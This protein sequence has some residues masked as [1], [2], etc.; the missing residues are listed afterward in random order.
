[1]RSRPQAPP[2]VRV[3]SARARRWTLSPLNADELF[4]ALGVLPGARSVKASNGLG[5]SRVL[6]GVEVARAEVVDE[7][8]LRKAWRERAKG[9]PVPLLVVVDDPERDGAVRT[10]GPL[11]ADDPV[12]VVE[13][14]DL[15][16]VLEEL[17]SLSKLRAVRELA[18][19]LDRL[20]R[21]GIAG[22]SVKGL[23]TEH[24]YGTRLP[25]SPRWSELQGLVP[26]ARG[27]WREVLESFG[28]EVE[29]LK[30]RGYLARH[31][32]RPVAVVWPLNDPAAF[33]R[34]DHE[35]R[36]PEGLLVN[37]CIHEGASYGLL[38]SGA[39]LRRFRAQ[40]QQGSAVSS[41]L[42][43]DAASLA[44]DHRPLLGLLSPAYLAGDGFEGL[45]REAA[46]FGAELRERLDRSIR[47]D[48]LPPLGLEL[49]RWAEGEGRDLSD[50]ETRG[51]RR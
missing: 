28:Y 41:Y 3:T 7:R 17:P 16:R 51:E 6:A 44:A 36:P 21:T 32:G 8:A 38:A 19:E 20:D 10:L 43:L 18:E 47:E 40:P 46:A 15:L 5:S 22:L 24:L 30:R 26:D 23:G 4:E 42:E 12:R 35:G 11:G 25:G 49:G 39:R 14:D 2:R 45:M 13:A 34:L 1:M 27:S 29:R 33:A 9:G 50:D 37:D 48:V 31:E